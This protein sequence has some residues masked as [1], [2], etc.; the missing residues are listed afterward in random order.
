MRE[1]VP[2]DHVGDVARV[3]GGD[4]DAVGHAIEGHHC[5]VITLIRSA[6]GEGRGVVAGIGRRCIRWSLDFVDA[7]R[8]R[9]D[10]VG[11][12][13]AGVSPL[14]EDVSRRVDRHELEEVV[15]QINCGGNSKWTDELDG[16]DHFE[17]LAG[18]GGIVDVTDWPLQSG[19]AI[20]CAGVGVVRRVDVRLR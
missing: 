6:G 1:L 15:G 9:G 11:D 12:E 13:E 2:H 7:L 18:A 8:Q 20:R 17:Y 10:R 16:D 14:R 5:L 19:A 4:V 3:S